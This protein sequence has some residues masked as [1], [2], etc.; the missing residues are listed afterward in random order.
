MSISRPPLILFDI[1]GTLLDVHGAGRLSFARTLAHCFGGQNEL[2][3][4]RFAG[5][6]DLDL[7][8]RLL[9]ERGRTPTPADEAAFFA[10]LP[11]EL[12]AA[13]AGRNPAEFLY[14]GV[15]ALLERLSAGR[16]VLG[17]VTG[18]IADCAWIK[19]EAAGI[20]GHF[21][22]GAF[23]HE[24]ADRNEIARLA[25][26]RAEERVGGAFDRVALIGD[27][28]NDVRAARAIGALAVAVT[29]GSHT[30][31]ELKASGADLV[32]SDLSDAAAISARLGVTAG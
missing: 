20:H 17:L 26:R 30:E 8:H 14:P 23:G 5:A 19:L 24:H 3:H 11:I 28:P 10:R 7:L 29:T 18:N 2:A 6:T 25:L 1:D 12:R 21:S 22:L 15:R 31:A 16:C 27:T 4:I 32:L 9:R 13:L